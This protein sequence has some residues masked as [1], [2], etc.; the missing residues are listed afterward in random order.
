M[1]VFYIF[2]IKDEFKYLYKDNA[3]QLYNLLKQIYY[4]GKDDIS[5]GENIF[6]QLIDPIDKDFLD[7]KLFIKL[8]REIPY[9]KRGDIHIMN[10]LYKDEISRLLVKNTYMKIE[11][12]SSFSSFFNYLSLVDENYFACDFLYTDFFFLDSIKTL[13]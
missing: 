13:V 5:Y 2:K 7:R 10:N 3:S 6:F 8:H 12:E 9:S 1:R 4:L 11:S